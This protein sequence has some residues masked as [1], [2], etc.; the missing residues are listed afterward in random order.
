MEELRD[1]SIHHTAQKLAV[2][3][4][5]MKNYDEI[6]KKVKVNENQKKKA[7]SI[8]VLN[9]FNATIQF[10]IGCNIKFTFS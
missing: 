3:I 2:A 1:A 6:F 9:I 7:N 5:A 8:Y 10:V 4:K